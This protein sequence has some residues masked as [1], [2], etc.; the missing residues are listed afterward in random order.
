MALADVRDWFKKKGKGP[1]NPTANDLYSGPRAFGEYRP[2]AASAAGVE[3]QQLREM[4]T[5]GWSNT[6]RGAFGQMQRQA[7]QAEQAQRGAVMQRAAATGQMNGGMA[8]AGALGAQQ[9]AANRAMDAGVQ[10]AS[11]GADRRL[12]ANQASAAV[13]QAGAGAADQ[14]NQWASGMQMEA[15]T[16]AYDKAKSKKDSWW[17]RVSGGIL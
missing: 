14:F 15:Q 9:G 7:N 3:A 16:T 6:D 4:G 1:K 11:I 2:E 12:A 8:F 5:T 13:R 17:K 10:Q